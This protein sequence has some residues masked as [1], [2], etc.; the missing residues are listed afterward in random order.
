MVILDKRKMKGD[1]TDVYDYLKEGHSEESFCLFSQVS[2]NSL[3]G[4]RHKLSQERLRLGTGKNFF[5][6]RL[7]KHWK[8]TMYVALRDL[9]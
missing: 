4:N 8:G 9:V 7:V 6:M 2:S 1:L 5:M 3:Q